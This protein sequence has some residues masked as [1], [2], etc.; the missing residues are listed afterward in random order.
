[1]RLSHEKLRRAVVVS[2]RDAV[3]FDITFFLLSAI[4][5]TGCATALYGAPTTKQ[6]AV[7]GISQSWPLIASL[8]NGRLYLL[9][10]SVSAIVALISQILT[11]IIRL[12]KCEGECIP[13]M[14]VI[15]GGVLYIFSA[16]AAI[17][18][19]LFFKQKER[20]L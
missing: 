3:K 4:Q 15:L 17:L 10:L 13:E 1:M 6:F 19:R 12:K 20:T 8:I 11:G 14:A 7:W 2:K 16:G 9:S 5:L 18:K